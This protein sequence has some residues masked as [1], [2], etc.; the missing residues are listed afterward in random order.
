MK[1]YLIIL[2]SIIF[3]SCTLEL[4]LEA[5]EQAQELVMNCVIEANRDSIGLRLWENKNILATTSTE[6][7]DGALVTVFEND[8]PF[9]RLNEF[10]TVQDDEIDTYYTTRN[11]PTMQPGN[12]YRIE[13]EKNGYP[14]VRAEQVIPT[15]PNN[16][17]A[18]ALCRKCFCEF[19]DSNEPIQVE[20]VINDD[21]GPDYYHL[22]LNYSI[23]TY[24]F[25][26]EF[27][28]IRTAVLGEFFESKS[29]V[30]EDHIVNGPNRP[31]VFTDELFDGQQ[32]AIVFT[33]QEG[34]T[35]EP[36]Q[37][38][39]CG[40]D[41]A[42][43]ALIEIELRKVSEAYYNYYNTATLQEQAQENPFAE[44]VQVYNNIEFGKGIFGAYSSIR[45][46]IPVSSESW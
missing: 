19:K 38:I 35:V 44:P 24:D 33:V 7:V 13:V 45:R 9:A 8:Q 36:L 40:Q 22:I 17:G 14:I 28:A 34:P 43:G 18:R 46:S 39:Y 16:F 41:L 32:Q 42:L 29:P 3:L 11:I 20:V 4:E 37:G 5:P 23:I 10:F 25:V 21:P 12:T 26:P 2:S 31:L 27:R 6:H 30:F 15:E 1:L